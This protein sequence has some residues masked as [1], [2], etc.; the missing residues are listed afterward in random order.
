MLM[1]KTS[2]CSS[3]VSE[4]LFKKLIAPCEGPTS[5]MSVR[6]E[7]LRKSYLRKFRSQK[8]DKKREEATYKKWLS[9]EQRC[10]EYNQIIGNCSDFSLLGR[11]LSEMRS[12]I[13]GVIGL[14][15]PKNLFDR[16]GRFTPGASYS[17][18]RGVH[19]SLKMDEITVTPDVSLWLRSFAGITSNL[20][21]V[22]GNRMCAV[23]KTIEVDRLIAIEP[24]GNAFLQQCVGGF[25]K[26]CLL[27]K[28][29]INLW[30]QSVN[31]D[32]AFRALVDELATID[33]EAA[34]DSVCTE[35]V[36]AVLPQSWFL[37]LDQLR[38]KKSLYNGR[39]R[40]LDKFS[41]MGN[42]YTFELETLIFWACCKAV[43][44]D[45]D[46]MVYGD[47]IIVSQRDAA[48]CIAA[49]GMIGFKTNVEKSF[50]TG[51]YFESCGKHYYDLEDVTP[52]FQKEPIVCVHSAMRAHNRLIRWAL[53][54][55]D[56]RVVRG[57]CDYL[58]KR[59]GFES[60]RVPFGVERDD[61]WLCP[62]TH[63]TRNIHG[64]FHTNVVKILQYSESAVNETNC[65]SYKLYNPSHQNESPKGYPDSALRDTKRTVVRRTVIW[66]SSLTS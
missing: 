41:S 30:D 12:L 20:A 58:R 63:I 61:G 57:A 29:G 59:Y 54:Y 56:F 14:Q 10:F 60:C 1:K 36:R 3:R 50:V 19:Y 42:G 27:A 45:S 52:I 65:L 7:L 37:A 35:L 25:F 51:R 32:G 64:D 21:I 62:P 31:Q 46:L 11:L 23:P 40:Y 9:S 13:E 55:D 2:D 8:S 48:N 24:S 5:I 28:A 16:R 22:P 17:T 15:P 34:S 43:C 49:L 53:R 66:R 38:S 47:D 6:H 18:K 33:L 26:D 4:I 39:W 44:R